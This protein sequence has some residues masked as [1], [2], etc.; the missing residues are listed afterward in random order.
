MIINKT[1]F[2]I[3]F[4]GGGT[5]YPSWFRQNKGAVLST[6]I[7]KYCYITLRMLPPFFKHKHHIVYSKDE[8]V[9]KLDHIKHPAVKEI[10]KYMKVK[11][12]LELHYD[13]DLPA[14]SGLGS[15][16]AF[17]V[18]LLK[19]IYSLYGRSISKK[20]LA[21]LAI[22][23]EQNLIR[24]NVGSQDQIAA[25]YGGLNKIQFYQDGTFK[26][27]DIELS[28]NRYDELQD[29]ILFFYTGITRIASKIAK[30]QIEKISS[31]KSDL[32]DMYEMVDESIAILRNDNKPIVEFGKMLN[33]SWKI[34]RGLT[35]KISN[36]Q[37]DEM[38]NSA[39]ESGAVGG[40][41]TGAGGG[42]FMMI[43]AEPSYHDNIIESLKNYLHVPILFTKTGSKILFNS[44]Q[45]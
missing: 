14:R 33:E 6:T 27:T 44:E 10:F 11:D 28:K 23:I 40:K 34:K 36:K 43:F 38:Y 32:S 19:S 37:I 16:S 7:N 2:R 39:I 4:F 25:S 45:N 35:N 22:H 42:G 3:S 1:P 5:D 31:I 30:E 41:I 9:N 26:V 20:S 13:A 18:G 15:S 24:E 21:E 12:G 29:H 8:K 17:S